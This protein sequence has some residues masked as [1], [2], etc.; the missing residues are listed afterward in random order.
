MIRR[1]LRGFGPHFHPKHHHG[2]GFGPALVTGVGRGIGPKKKRINTDRT[3]YVK[4]YLEICALRVCEIRV[5]FSFC[6]GQACH[7]GGGAG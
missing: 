2:F 5:L 7:H 1:M 4:K 3:D 6:F